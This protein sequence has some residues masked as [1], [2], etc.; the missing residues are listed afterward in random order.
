MVDVL[1]DGGPEA[2]TGPGGPDTLVPIGRN[3]GMW[4]VVL[5]RSAGHAAEQ[6]RDFLAAAEEQQHTGSGLREVVERFATDP[7]LLEAMCWQNPTIVNSWLGRY[8]TE[9][10]GGTK[11]PTYYRGKLLTLGVYLQRYATRNETIGFFGPIA[12]AHLDP[13]RDLLVEVGGKGER[14]RHTTYFEPWAL[15]ALARA[16]EA[17]PEVR[18]HLPVVV[19]Q[20]GALRDDTFVRPRRG[21]HPLTDDQR[22]VLRHLGG[23]GYADELLTAVRAA[24]GPEWDRAR[25]T[26]VLDALQRAECLHWG[27]DITVVGGSEEVLDAQLARVPEGPRGRLRDDLHRLSRLRREVCDAAGDATGV[28]RATNALAESF[29]TISGVD[30]SVQKRVNPDCRELLYHDVTVDWDATLG[31]RAVAG[32]AGPLELLMETCRYAS[33]RFATG[34]EDR[35]RVALRRDP[36]FEA[37]FDE[38]LPELNDR[39]PGRVVRGVL[40]E[41]RQIVA[42]L[43]AAEPGVEAPDGSLVYRSAALRERW[44]AAFAAPRA[45]W[46]A[47]ELHS[48]DIMLAQRDDGH[49]WVLGELHTTINPLDYRFC[50]E[51]QPEPGRLEALIDAAT[52]PDRFIAAVPPTPRLS[53]RT[54]PPP[55]AYLPDKHRYWTLWPRTSMPAAVPKRSCVDLRVAERDGT[56][57]VLDAAG[58]VVTRLTEFLGEFLSLALYN[59]LS[60]F[61]EA[62]HSPRVRID[63]LVVQRAYQRIPV[64]E[65]A[66]LL[67]A[68]PSRV[69]M[70]GFFRA[71]GLPR[72]SFVRVPGEPKPVFCDA[73]SW[74]TTHNVVRLV[75]KVA[76]RPEAMVKVQEML[77]D[78]DDLWLT[79]PDGRTR[80]SE[81]RFVLQDLQKAGGDGVR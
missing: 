52:P 63:D 69:E 10:V 55:A 65:F 67:S 11:R 43:L 23:S 73:R 46:S 45:G 61:P 18:W 54:A 31:A 4:P 12:W 47:A 29:E 6:L 38:L 5:L 27:F 42:D 8:A 2:V 30:R 74:V 24:D 14:V 48:T 26:G 1:D 60:L 51:N 13:G 25:L 79:G 3:W 34:I 71:R 53:P 75:R 64:R 49:L 15:T 41:V 28:W 21:P 36:S 22:L 78:F 76:D 80:T 56:V 58:Q 77:P 68:P 70:A 39:R 72:Y 44:R 50:L 81:F 33:W 17:D 66:P 35:A 57:V 9:G 37:V 19:N 40:A 20:A 59:T 32:L 62:D 16:W 7:W